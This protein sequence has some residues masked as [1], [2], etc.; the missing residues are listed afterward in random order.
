MPPTGAV[1]V[2][3]DFPPEL[4]PVAKALQ[5]LG[6]E[7]LLRIKTLAASGDAVDFGQLEE[8]LHAE[9]GE[10]GRLVVESLKAQRE[11]IR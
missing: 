2:N 7:T 6:E 5:A 9:L 8:D 3:L 11:P 4:A 10:L 1:E